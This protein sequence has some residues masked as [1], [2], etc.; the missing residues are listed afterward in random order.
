MEEKGNRRPA[1]PDQIE[2]MM[3]NFKQTL[4]LSYHELYVDMVLLEALKRG[5]LDEI[6]GLD[7]FFFYD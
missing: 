6:E 3:V 5:N 4:E 2:N 1:T 7:N